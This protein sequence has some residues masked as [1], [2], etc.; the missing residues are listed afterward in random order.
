MTTSRAPQL[1]KDDHEAAQA[2]LA[3]LKSYSLRE[4]EHL[5]A[6]GDLHVLQDN[7]V[8]AALHTTRHGREGLEIIALATAQTRLRQGYASAL[9][10]T[11]LDAHPNTDIVLKANL[12]NTAAIKLYKRAGFVRQNDRT[13][14]WWYLRL[15]GGHP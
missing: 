4:L 6:T 10:E 9:L 14:V 7:G 5:A 3:Q 8:K 12:E 1:T 2:I 13:E 15:P 11:F